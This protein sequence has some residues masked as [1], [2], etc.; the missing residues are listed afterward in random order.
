MSGIVDLEELLAAMSPEIQ[1]NEYVF[2]SVSGKY[3]DYDYLGPIASFAEAEGLT[4]IVPVSAADRAKLKYE[5]TYKQITLKVHSSLA[6]VG[7]TAA[8]SAK[9]A[10]QGVSANVVAAY[11]HDHVFVPAEKATEALK[12]LQELSHPSP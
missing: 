10:A 8:V 5:N 4:L 7:L 1:E 11:Y 6:A 3:A 12:A 9:L 2:C